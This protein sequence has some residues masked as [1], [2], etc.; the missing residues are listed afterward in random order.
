MYYPNTRQQNMKNYKL[1][2]ASL[3]VLFIAAYQSPCLAVDLRAQAENYR[4]Q[5]YVAQERGDVQTAITF[6]KK[7]VSLV[8]DYAAAHNDLGVLYESM[9]ELDRAEESYLKAVSL[10]EY[11]LASYSN[12]AYLYEKQGKLKKAA[13]YWRKR[14][15]LG[16]PDDPWTKKAE[17]NFESL[18]D[19]SKELR[20]MFIDIEVEKLNKEI[21]QQRLTA[22]NIRSI[23]AGQHFNQGKKYFEEQLFREAR[24]EFEKALSL[25]PNDPAILEYYRKAKEKE[26]K[27]EL[28][29]HL[30]QGINYYDAGDTNRAR[31]ELKDALSVIPDNSNQ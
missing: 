3:A 15:E 28:E 30:K 17:L 1:I 24:I 7:A 12:L 31:E 5:G 20:D 18:L 11:Y 14:V 21:E 23:E 13:Y 9:G 27:E 4:Q 19:M 29:L 6:Y 26:T 2:I 10:D 16:D 8:P 25:T 22:F